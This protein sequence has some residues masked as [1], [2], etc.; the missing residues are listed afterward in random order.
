MAPARRL[1]EFRSYLTQTAYDSERDVFIETTVAHPFLGDAACGAA[2]PAVDTPVVEGGPMTA[3][4][5]LDH[6]P[7]RPEFPAP[8]IRIL[9]QT[10][11]RIRAAHSNHLGYPYNLVGKSPLPAGFGGLLI[12]NL[13]D[14]YVGSH[15]ASEV[16]ELEREAVAWLMRSLGVRHARRFLGLGRCQ[17]HRRQSLGALSCARGLSRR[18]AALQPRGPL[19]DPEGRPHSPDRRHL[20]RLYPGRRHRPPGPRR[21][22]RRPRRQ[23]ADRG[24][25]LRHD[26]EG[27]PR[28]HRRRPCRPRRGRSRAGPA[29]HPH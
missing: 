19:L 28:R 14:P 5:G 18:A 4:C 2:G 8:I 13:G 12:N 6:D 20:G 29:L 27:R 17:R 15:Y 24:A 7:S 10:E 22:P 23:P 21:C 9:D 1:T 25:H 11:A 16:C 3:T 26:G